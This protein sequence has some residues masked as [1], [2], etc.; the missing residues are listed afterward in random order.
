M[1]DMIIRKPTINAARAAIARLRPAVNIY[2]HEDSPLPSVTEVRRLAPV[3]A[4]INGLE[5]AME[6]LSNEQLQAKTAEFR[7]RITEMLRHE[8]QAVVQ[9]AENCR[10][11]K[12]IDERQNFKD[13]HKAAQK[14]LFAAKQHALDVVLPEAFAV[15]RETGKR[16]L[17]MRHY[18]VQMLGGMALH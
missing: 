14:E 16:L 10:Q 7:Q 1:L 13:A 11:A 18:D 9:A 4:R 8:A 12:N 17:N 3:V 6:K 2:I 15:V 5:S